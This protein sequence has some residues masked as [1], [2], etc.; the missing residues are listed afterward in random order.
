MKNLSVSAFLVLLFGTAAAFQACSESPTYPV[1]TDVKTTRERTVRAATL[2]SGTTQLTTE[3]VKEYGPHG[4][5]SWVYG[6]PVDYGALTPDNSSAGTYTVG[7]TLLS[8]FTMSDVHI[9]DKES[10]S[11]A[12]FGGMST[13]PADPPQGFGNANTSAYSPVMLSTTHVLDAAVQTIN[14]L[15]AGPMPFDFG[16]SLGDDANSNQYNEL[17]WFIDVMD[18]KAI[19]PSSGA[20][21]GADSI[22]YQKPYRA[23][24]LNRSIPWYQ[25]M[26]NHDQYWCGTLLVNDYDRS[27][28]VGDTVINI[29]LV[30]P[31]AFPSFEGHGYYMGVIDGA[32]EYGTITGYGED[33]KV[34]PPVIAADPQRHAL[35]TATSNTSSW[36][37]EFQRTTSR[38]LGHGFTQSKLDRDFASYSFEPKANLPLKVIVL[39]DTCKENPYA[40][41]SSYARACLDQQR[42]DWLVGELDQGQADGKLMIIAAHIPVGPLS[43][44]PDFQ[45][46]PGGIPNEAHLPLFLSR[47]TCGASLCELDHYAPMLPYT[48]VTDHTLLEKLHNYPNLIL[49]IS[50]HRHINTVTP[51]PAPDTKGPEFGF[52]EVETPSLR[53]F[54]QQFRTF[55]VVFNSNKTI[56]IFVTD[57]DPA[58]QDDPAVQPGSPAAKSR[59]YAIGANRI[60]A[61][62]PIAFTDTTAHVYN[63][64]LVKPLSTDMQAKLLA[65]FP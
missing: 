40:T 65:L 5:S 64:E 18:G 49:W 19:T 33:S 25:T 23:A 61:G 1:S 32:T 51:Q 59:G 10:P 4:Y 36:M 24:G 39:D 21:R 22:D 12:I 7:A 3:Q 11:Q 50:G 55:R 27:V 34:A 48:V 60:A 37:E 41:D 62:N 52:W 9:V 8:F 29:A 26:G 63:A 58:V 6:G 14:A 30:G 35:A 46:K 20:H 31:T 2:P 42:Y 45:V 13:N 16:I 17:R 15:H 53:D 28:L 54:P 47:P 44:V 57:V 38:P 43:N 56:S